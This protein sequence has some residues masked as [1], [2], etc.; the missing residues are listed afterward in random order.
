MELIGSLSIDIRSLCVVMYLSVEE[1]LEHKF[2]NV[3]VF[4]DW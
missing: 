1:K 2:K 3:S 4:E